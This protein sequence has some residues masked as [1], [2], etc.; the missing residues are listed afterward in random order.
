MGS[1]SSAQQASRLKEQQNSIASL[2]THA[3]P[4]PPYLEQRKEVLRRVLD[5][6]FVEPPLQQPTQIKLRPD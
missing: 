6:G 3:Q 2:D 4:A 1:S 5:E